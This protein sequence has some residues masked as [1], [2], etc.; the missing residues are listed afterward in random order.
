MQ[1]YSQEK[2]FNFYE[3][4]IADETEF[5]KKNYGVL[6]QRGKLTQKWHMHMYIVVLL[7]LKNLGTSN[8]FPFFK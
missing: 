3:N 1:N 8:M 4:G 6:T 2:E 5:H 7:V